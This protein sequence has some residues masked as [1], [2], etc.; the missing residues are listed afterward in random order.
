MHLKNMKVYKMIMQKNGTSTA[1][2]VTGDIARGLP[3]VRAK[4]RTK[5]IKS[6]S[7]KESFRLLGD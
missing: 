1:T 4:M 2:G 7:K 3:D 5:E 6:I